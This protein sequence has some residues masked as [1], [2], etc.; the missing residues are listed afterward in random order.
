MPAHP[1]RY[2]SSYLLIQHFD[3]P[4]NRQPRSTAP[5]EFSMHQHPIQSPGQ[6][7]LQNYMYLRVFQCHSFYSIHNDDLLEFYAYECLCFIVL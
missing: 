7:L 2:L 4:L 6:Y 5:H 1:L 3:S